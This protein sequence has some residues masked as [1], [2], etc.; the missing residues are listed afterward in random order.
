MVR[1]YNF[2]FEKEDVIN[3]DLFSG[4][5]LLYWIGMKSNS[6]TVRRFVAEYFRRKFAHNVFWI[7]ILEKKLTLVS[8]VSM[9]SSLP[10]QVIQKTIRKSIMKIPKAK[11]IPLAVSNI[12][13]DM[14]WVPRNLLKAILTT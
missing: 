3:L 8:H 6:L 13:K 5:R 2:G 12:R 4:H 10:H 1:H 11:Q 14:R 7:S 9:T